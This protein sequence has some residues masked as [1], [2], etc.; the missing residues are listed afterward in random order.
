MEVRGASRTT[1]PGGLVMNPVLCGDCGKSM[2]LGRDRFG[3][4]WLCVCGSRHGAHPD[5][6]PHGIPADAKTRKARSNAHEIFDRLWKTGK[7]SRTG[8]YIWMR[9]ALAMT[10]DEAHVSKFDIPACHRLEK[11]VR[12][13]FPDMFFSAFDD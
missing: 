13:E 2:A 8:A 4:G 12:E 6:S 10:P 7:F 3:R 9:T 11:A 1:Q 5:G